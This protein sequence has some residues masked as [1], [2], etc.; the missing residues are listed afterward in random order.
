MANLNIFNH[1]DIPEQ[2]MM[3]LVEYVRGYLLRTSLYDVEDISQPFPGMN[4]MLYVDFD[5]YFGEIRIKEVT[6]QDDLHRIDCERDSQI[7]SWLLTDDVLPQVNKK[8]KEISR[9]A[10]QIHEDCLY[11]LGII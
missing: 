4:V 1:L 9:Q 7:L 2:T 3:Y 6:V 5:I 10:R 8:N 11:E